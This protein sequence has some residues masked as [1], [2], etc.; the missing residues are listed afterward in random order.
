MVTRAHA[1]RQVAPPRSDPE[2]AEARAAL[3]AGAGAGR[4]DLDACATHVHPERTAQLRAAELRA[5]RAR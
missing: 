2:F 3:V 1:A 5:R 4:T